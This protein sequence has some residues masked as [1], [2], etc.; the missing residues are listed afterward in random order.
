MRTK[1]ALRLKEQEEED[2]KANEGINEV[3]SKSLITW[4]NNEFSKDDHT[5][6][7]TSGGTTKNDTVNI[8]S[9]GSNLW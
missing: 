4:M 5:I 6:D 3:G 8:E 1:I 7:E 2:S 9:L